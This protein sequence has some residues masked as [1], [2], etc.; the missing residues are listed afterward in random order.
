MDF[1]VIP[2]MGALIAKIVDF[3]KFVRAKEWNGVV[4][5]AASWV[6]GV[7]VVLLVA[8]T[9]FASFEVNNIVLGEMNLASQVFLGLIATSV[10]SVVYDFRKAIDPSDS[11]RTPSLL[12][13]EY[14]DLTTPTTDST[15]PTEVAHTFNYSGEFSPEPVGVVVEDGGPQ[16]YGHTP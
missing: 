3:A 1:V 16:T 4:T 9:D 14:T 6:A 2:V 12:T 10:I 7:L 5:Q 8:Q 13:G 15:E 11:A